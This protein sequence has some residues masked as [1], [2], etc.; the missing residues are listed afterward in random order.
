MKRHFYL[1]IFLHIF[2]LLLYFF[3]IQILGLTNPTPLTEISSLRFVRKGCILILSQHICTNKNISMMH[4]L[5]ATHGVNK[6][7]YSS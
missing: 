6:P 7:Y 5:L 3:L 1:H 2:I 4:T